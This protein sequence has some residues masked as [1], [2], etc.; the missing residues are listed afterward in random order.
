MT[1]II[2]SKLVSD[3]Q[4]LSFLPKHF[5]TMM[6]RA[7]QAIYNTLK[8]MCSS[9]EGGYWRFYELS[10]RGFYLAPDMDE[11]LPIYVEGNGYDGEVS[12]D[13]AG[14]ITTLCVLNQLCW[15]TKSDKTIQQYY[16]LRDYIEYHKEAADI[17][18]AID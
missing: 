9:Y 15:K 5:G 6:I 3:Q 8:V 4:R 10:N 12:A 2:T 11:P 1:T 17:Y 18:A 14:I 16:L 7:E 13:A